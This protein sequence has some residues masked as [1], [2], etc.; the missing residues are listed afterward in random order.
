MSE[1][2][3]IKTGTTREILV[4]EGW[5]D[6][7]EEYLDPDLRFCTPED[8]P[9]LIFHTPDGKKI[10]FKSEMKPIKP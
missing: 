5:F 3:E 8:V 4:N 2:K 10:I 6:Q 1:S 7:L 9:T